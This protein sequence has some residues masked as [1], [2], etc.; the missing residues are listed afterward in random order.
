[1]NSTFIFKALFSFLF[2]FGLAQITK[3]KVFTKNEIIIVAN[4]QGQDNQKDKKQEKPDNKR[5]PD[6]K[7]EPKQPDI[8]KVPKA[9]KQTRPPVVIKAKIKVKPRI[10]RPNIKRP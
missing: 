7:Q 5:K 2:I 10:V 6:H 4:Y 1:M 3:A 8:R 9:R